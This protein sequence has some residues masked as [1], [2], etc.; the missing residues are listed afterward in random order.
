M[1][2]HFSDLSAAGMRAQMEQRIGRWTAD[3]RTDE[4]F[5]GVRP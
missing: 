2:A 4:T 3:F 5:T 1:A